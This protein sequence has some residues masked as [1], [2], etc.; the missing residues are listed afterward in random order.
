[1]H[2][3]SI[4]YSLIETA[5]CAARDA[6]A[7]RV[8]LVRLRLGVLSGVVEDALR[9]GFEVAT[10]NTLLDGARLEIER[11]PVMVHCSQCNQ[12]VELP[13]IQRFRCPICDTPAGRV[14]QGRELEL[15]S[16]EIES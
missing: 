4:A 9:F 3:L 15:S 16:I 7:Q 14:V 12:I 10:Q 13:S 5:E 2:E 6:D 8:T 1:M 11:L